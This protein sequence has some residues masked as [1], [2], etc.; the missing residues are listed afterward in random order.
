MAYMLYLSSPE[1]TRRAGEY[2]GEALQPNATVILTGDLGAGKTQLTKGIARAMGV[3]EDITSP[4]FT[5]EIAYDGTFMPLH[6]FDLYRLDNVDELEDTGIFDALEDGGVCVVE[7]GEEFADEL[8]DDRIDI[9]LTRVDDSSAHSDRVHTEDADP[10]GVSTAVSD[11]I[12][13]SSFSAEPIRC[14]QCVA[15]GT[16]SEEMLKTFAQALN[17][18]EHN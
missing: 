3:T 11:A 8:G 12:D 17:L 16:R 10:I 7:W 2:L 1:E 4:T 15:T 5:I 9:T 13:D 14:M 6:H 18:S